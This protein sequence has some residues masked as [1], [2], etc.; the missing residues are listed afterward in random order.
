MNS[1][2][3]SS[4]GGH[5]LTGRITIASKSFFPHRIPIVINAT[6]NGIKFTT[7][8]KRLSARLMPYAEL[9]LAVISN[10]LGRKKVV[11]YADSGVEAIR[12][13][14][15]AKKISDFCRYVNEN[16]ISL[17]ERTPSAKYKLTQ[18]Q[19]PTEHIPQ[20]S[21]PTADDHEPVLDLLFNPEKLDR[22][23]LEKIA[24]ELEIDGRNNTSTKTSHSDGRRRSRAAHKSELRNLFAKS[25]QTV[26]NF[27]LNRAHF[28]NTFIGALV[29]ALGALTV[30]QLSGIRDTDPGLAAAINPTK[31]STSSP[32]PIL[33]AEHAETSTDEKQPRPLARLVSIVQNDTQYHKLIS[34]LKQQRIRSGM[35]TLDLNKRLGWDK[36][37]VKG[38]ESGVIRAEAIDIID[39]SV[40]I[41]A[42]L[43]KLLG[44][45]K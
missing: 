44:S 19:A 27:S 36:K 6:E 15:S 11:I 8:R 31:P 42:D 12:C 3:P 17:R 41:H 16:I 45:L 18:L 21:E 7:H 25:D 10:F 20:T 39:Y 28:R 2:S 34:I 1:E 24:D 33:H 35:S 9:H 29:V 30:W 5:F 43:Y 40:A 32:E 13:F 26:W 14:D 38:I 22:E 4:D 37:T 23:F